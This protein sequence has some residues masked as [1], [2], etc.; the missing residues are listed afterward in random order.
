M[1]ADERL[2]SPP[3]LSAVVVTYKRTDLLEPCLESLRSALADVDE[4]TELVVI[5]TGS[6]DAAAELVSTAFSDVRLIP[7][8]NLGYAGAARLAVERS[9]GEWIALFNDDITVE[10]GALARLLEVGRSNPEIGSVAPQMR[11]FDRRGT[12]NSAGIEVDRLGLASD[13]LLGLPIEASE[14][15]PTTVF[16]ASGGAALYR[17]AMLDDVG[18]FDSTFFAYLEDV[19]LAWRAQMRGWRAVYS[20]RSIVY[21]HHSASFEHGSTSKHFL[22]GRNRVAVVAK[23]ASRRQLL[24]YG[25]AMAAY[26]L[27]YVSFVAVTQRTLAPLRG[28]LS[29]VADW[30]RYR[31]AVGVERRTVPLMRRNGFLKALRRHRAWPSG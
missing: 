14:T 2:S 25:L 27:G 9:L 29:G 20:P 3:A 22:V 31:H 5:D 24:R 19:D 26:D 6:Q 13:R 12:I 21:H 10:P 18:G 1:P 7:S 4:P 11:F 15:E 30:R 28:R 17:R 23:N 16:G 8:P